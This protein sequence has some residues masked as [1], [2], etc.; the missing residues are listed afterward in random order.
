MMI[1]ALAETAMLLIVYCV[2]LIGRAPTMAAAA[3]THEL[4]AR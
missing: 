1:A 4:E 2:A 3:T